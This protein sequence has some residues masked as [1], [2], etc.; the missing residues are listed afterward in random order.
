MGRRRMV[1]RPGGHGPIAFGAR[2]EDYSRSLGRSDL[3]V[4]DGL[5]AIT[6]GIEYECCEII[7]PVLRM[8]PRTTIIFS[9]MSQRRLMK[10]FD[11]IA[12]RSSEGHVKTVARH[13]D[14]LRT[15][16]DRKLITAAWPAVTNRCL[17]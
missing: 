10:R 11:G 6:V 16:P 12:G 17:I 9:T 8:Q 14:A 1:K 2:I 5:D 3:L 4:D 15:Q 7:R 13:N